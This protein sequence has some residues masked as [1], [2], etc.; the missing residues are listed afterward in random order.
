VEVINVKHLHINVP[1]TVYAEFHKLFPEQ[2]A[3]SRFIR[4]VIVAAVQNAS[5]K[6]Y[7]ANVVLGKVMG[8]GETD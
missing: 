4:Q 6:D 5:K 2:G 7:F 1:D 3:K 8:D